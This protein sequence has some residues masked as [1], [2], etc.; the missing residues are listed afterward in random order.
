MEEVKHRGGVF[1][2]AITIFAILYGLLYF[3]YT[4]ILFFG[5]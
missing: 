3:I 5:Q 1:R 4:A 2:P